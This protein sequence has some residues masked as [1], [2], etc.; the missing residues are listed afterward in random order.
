MKLNKLILTLCLSLGVIL[1][2]AQSV[3]DIIGKYFEA[4]GGKEKLDAIKSL[5]MHMS[6]MAGPMEIPIEINIKKPNK[7]YTTVTVQGMNMRTGF[8]GNAGWAINPFQGDTVPHKMSEEE[9]REAQDQA[10]LNGPL[11]DYQKKGNTVELMGKEDMEGSEVYKLKIIKKSGDVEYYFLDASSYYLLKSISKKNFQGKEIESETIF[12]D[13]KEL[14]G[15]GV[16]MAYAMEARQVGESEGQKMTITSIEPN[17]EME[18]TM[19]A[20]P[21]K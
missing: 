18:D 9:L 8:D 13:Y 14:P 16:I 12:S 10:D 7:M 20:M 1:S 19:F 6:M 4:M 2:N 17:L 5:R 15:T 21:T 11:Y 3:D